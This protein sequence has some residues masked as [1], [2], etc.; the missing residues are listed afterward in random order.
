MAE[1]TRDPLLHPQSSMQ[2]CSPET[3]FSLPARPNAGNTT[4][5]VPG[6]RGVQPGHSLQSTARGLPLQ[7]SLLLP[8][9]TTSPSLWADVQRHRRPLLG[10]RPAPTPLSASP[11][12]LACPRSPPSTAHHYETLHFT[13]RFL[14]VSK[15]CTVCQALCQ[16]LIARQMWF[17]PP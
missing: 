11:L 3:A 16:V 9:L 5:R 6:L 12:H 15:V 14:C 8:S 2:T 7:G 13:S 17:L 1:F 10:S 4:D